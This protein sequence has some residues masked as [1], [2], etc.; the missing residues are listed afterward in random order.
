MGQ[1][2]G[3]GDGD[4]HAPGR[5]PTPG[6]DLALARRALDEGDIKHAAHHVACALGEDANDD[7]ALAFADDL[8][9]RVDDPLALASLGDGEASYAIVAFRGLVLARLG[10]LAEAIDLV[11]QVVAVRPDVDYMAWVERWTRDDR[12]LVGIDPIRLAASVKRLAD[13]LLSSPSAAPYTNAT[14]DRVHDWLVELRA[15]LPADSALAM[16][17]A[18][19]LRRAGR[20][21]DALGVARAAHTAGPDYR[22]AIAVAGA[23]R[24]LRDLDGAVAAFEDASRFDPTDV[25][26]ILDVGDIRLEQARFDDALAAYHRALEL[27]PDNAWAVPS[28]LYAEVRLGRPDARAKLH[29]YAARN[30]GNQRAAELLGE[31]SQ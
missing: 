23:C 25:A 8:L 5:F 3:D 1:H 24:A 11:L 29:A 26:A 4:E 19:M 21:E 30:P 6:Q 16:M 28:A 9:S 7:D 27:E 2:D 17:H 31:L 18:I 13:G 10:E 22:T 20:L 12:A 14:F 15:R